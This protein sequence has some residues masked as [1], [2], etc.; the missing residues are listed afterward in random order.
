LGNQESVKLRSQ[1]FGSTHRYQ[2]RSDFLEDKQVF[3]LDMGSLLAG[4]R[5]R[6]DFEERVK[7]IVEEVRSAVTS[8]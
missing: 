4:T 1:K 7:G 6:G 8:S 2:R 3:S 5:Y